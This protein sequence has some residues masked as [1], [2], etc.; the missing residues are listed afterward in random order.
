MLQACKMEGFPL[1]PPVSTGTPL[2]ARPSALRRQSACPPTHQ[3]AALPVSYQWEI[4]VS[5]LELLV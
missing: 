5:S 4:G 2:L 1:V 3:P